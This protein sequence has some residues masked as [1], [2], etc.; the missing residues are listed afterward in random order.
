MDLV[1][2]NLVSLVNNKDKSRTSAGIYMH[3]DKLYIIE[4]TAPAGYPVPDFF[5]QSVGWLD[6]TGNGI[7]YLTIYHNG[8]PKP[9]IARRGG[10]GQGQGQGQ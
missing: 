8:Y 4:G 6:A 2:G 5:Q 1:E 10:Q 7:R 3:E 9:E